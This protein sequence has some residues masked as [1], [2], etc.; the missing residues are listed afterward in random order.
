MALNSNRVTLEKF[1]QEFN[2]FTESNLSTR[3]EALQIFTYARL[4]TVCQLTIKG[5][6]FENKNSGT[7]LEKM[8]KS[9]KNKQKK[10]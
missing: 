9:Q 10:R 8:I 6:Y 1:I 3:M 2:T 5:A 4:A 7:P